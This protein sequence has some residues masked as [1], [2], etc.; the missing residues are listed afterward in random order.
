MFPHPSARIQASNSCVGSPIAFNGSSD[1][2]G[3]INYSWSISNTYATTQPTFSYTFNTAGNYTVSLEATS[4]NGCKGTKTEQIN[5]YPN[6]EAAFSSKEACYASQTTFINLSSIAS[7]NV[8]NYSWDFG[9]NQQSNQNNPTHVYSSSGTFNAVLSITSDHGCPSN[10]AQQVIVHP[11]PLVNFSAGM[12]GCG[13]VTASFSENSSILSGTITDRLWNFGDGGVS[14]DSIPQHIYN[15]SGT[16]DVTLTVVSNYG[17]LS[18]DVKP[19]VITVYPQPLADFVADP[20]ITDIENPV[21]HFQNQSQGYST[22]QWVFGDGTGTTNI[23]NPTHTFSD[24][25]SYSAMLMTVNNFGCRDSIMR[26][27]EV[28][29]HSSLFIAN[30]FTPNGD[31]NNDDFRPFYKNM[32]DIKVWIYDRWGRLLT[33]WDGLNGSWDGYYEGKKCQTDTYVYKI[34]GTG[35]DGKFSEWVGHVSIVY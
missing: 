27:I 23:L 24:T 22:Y 28:K 2:S 19:N 12:Q 20:M 13:P 5:I 17:C 21:V 25:G 33:S 6:P 1:L 3:T 11:N 16:Y 35:L 18:S 30:C 31:G 4:A 15:Q 34:A 8:S 9:D 29:L 26:I 10:I 32:S 7:G 14:T